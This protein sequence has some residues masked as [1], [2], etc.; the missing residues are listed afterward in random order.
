MIDQIAV[1]VAM[2]KVVQGVQFVVGQVKRVVSRGDI[3]RGGK[4]FFVQVAHVSAFRQKIIFA[5]N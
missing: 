2:V 5:T 3:R 4:K 1:P